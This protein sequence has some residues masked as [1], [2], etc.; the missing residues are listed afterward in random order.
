MGPPRQ[1]ASVLVLALVLVLAVPADSESAYSSG[2]SSHRSQNPFKRRRRRAPPALPAPLPPPPAPNASG[3]CAVPRLT[4]VTQAAI[5]LA[6]QAARGTIDTQWPRI[7]NASHL[8][9]LVVGS[10]NGSVTKLDKKDGCD[11]ICGAQLAVCDDFDLQIGSAELAGLSSVNFSTIELD[12]LS[13]VDANNTCQR[14]TRA[15]KTLLGIPP[16]PPPM[17]VCGLTGQVRATASVAVK[18]ALDLESDG[19]GIHVTCKDAFKKWH[20]LL[21]KGKGHCTARTT[22]LQ[23]DVDVCGATCNPL[24]SKELAALMTVEVGA[25][26]FNFDKF[27]CNFDTGKGIPDLPDIAKFFSPHLF[28]SI[29]DALQPTLGKLITKELAQVLPAA[30]IPESCE[31][32]RVAEVGAR[33]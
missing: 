3:A 9:P 19:G 2:S 28:T 24:A 31:P 32:R 23:M 26:K 18:V 1:C 4:N 7:C 22:A 11:E 21:W 5:N 13:I 17:A 8:D 15:T 20:E 30:G 6:L 16:A 33:R 27:D 14:T 12:S 25:F 29:A 10:L